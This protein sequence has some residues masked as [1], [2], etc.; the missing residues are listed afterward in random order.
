MILTVL[1]P[2]FGSKISEYM[3]DHNWSDPRALQRSPLDRAKYIFSKLFAWANN[4]LKLVTLGNFIAFMLN[5]SK[6]NIW[7]WLLG[8]SLERIDPNQ[9]RGIDFTYINRLIVWNAI[10]KSV[11]DIL[12]FI[13]LSKIRSMFQ[14]SNKLTEY[15]SLD[16]DE[17]GSENLCPV[18]GTT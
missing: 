6:R 7:E 1:A 11:Q 2:Y 12:P 8:I 14:V 15:I 4:L 18:C 9:K 10:W 5:L 13:D 3:M 16:Q 17:L